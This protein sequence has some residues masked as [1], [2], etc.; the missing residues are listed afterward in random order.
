MGAKTMEKSI[1]LALLR[2]IGI[3]AHIDAG[4]TTTTER[5]L[6]YT[7]KTHRMGDV[8]AGDTET[9]WMCLEKERGITITSAATTCYWEDHQVN[10]ID[11]PGH[12]DFTVEVERSLRV[13]D[14]AVA[15]FCAVGGVEPQSE[16]VWRQADH[17]RIPRIAFINKMDRIGADFH[18]AVKMLENRLHARVIVTQLPIGSE[19]GFEG[20]VDLVEMRSVYWT[21]TDL[22]TKLRIECIPE[23]MRATV[24]QARVEMLES[25]AEQDVEFLEE[26][27]E[28]GETGEYDV[29]DVKSAIRRATIKNKGIPVLCG[30]AVR[31]KGVQLL[32]DAIVNYLP[33]PLDIPPVEGHHPQTGTGEYRVPS[34]EEPFC[35]LAFKMM[36]DPHG[37]LTFIRVYSGKLKVGSYL[38]NVNNEVRERVTRLFYMHAN[39]REPVEFVSAGD[40]ACAVGLTNTFTGNTLSERKYPILLESM[41]IPEPVISVAIEPKTK[42]DEDRL[43]ASLAELSEED[44]TLI[45]RRDAETNQTLISGMGE[46]HL[47]IVVQRMLREFKVSANVGKPQ[48]AYREAIKETQEAK[49]QLIRQTGGRG[50]FAEVLLRV[51]PLERGGGFEFENE[52]RE[53]KIPNDFIPSVENGV[54]E[55]MQSGVLAGYPMVDVKVTLLDG[56]YHPEDSTEM[57]FEVAASIAFKEALR[58]ASPVLLEPIM[59]LEI[60]VPEEYMG[61]VIGNLNSRRGK[62]LGIN[63]RNSLQYIYAEVPLSECFGYATTLRS[64]TQGR[65]DYIMQVSNHQ[66]VPPDVLAELLVRLRGY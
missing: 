5:M 33:S 58:K 64:L 6:Y 66:E 35:A 10:I 2:N 23:D 38:W 54:I 37:K 24:N 60:I 40:I 50:Q 29:A 34:V 59:R 48:V 56:D 57:A 61:E 39:K 44:P 49:G 19:D 20:V 3:M 11:T 27:L 17:Y 8:D 1:S 51:E 31:Y 45:V 65:G 12:V 46:L 62:V 52:I 28:K 55:S 14:G 7:G 32:L 41:D 21:E 30:A 63:G 18:R 4:K 42:A 47:E 15:L 13:L 9:D 43:A 53:G 36:S 22:G 16:T 25:L 26:Y